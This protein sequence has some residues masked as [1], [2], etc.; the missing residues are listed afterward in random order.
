MSQLTPQK[1]AQSGTEFGEQ[2]ALFGWVALAETQRQ[3]P[4]AI[5][6]Y[7][8]NNNAGKGDKI[9]G[10]RARQEGVRAGVADTF[11]PVARHG[12]H[13][14]YI[15]IKINPSHPR[16]QKLGKKGQPIAP[17][18]GKL[19]KDQEKFRDQVRLDGYGWAMAEGWEEAAEIIKQ[20]LS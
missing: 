8:N 10:A 4:D 6:L 15:E 20:Y 14:L 9:R 12:M 18:R 17:K 2:S 5:K 13:G 11:L 7:A 19:S 3:F 16:N 1:L